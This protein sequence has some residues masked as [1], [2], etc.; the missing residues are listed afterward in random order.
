MADAVFMY[1]VTAGIFAFLV[2]VVF[3]ARGARK[4][5]EPAESTA[6]AHSSEGSEKGGKKIKKFKSDGTPVYE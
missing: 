4:R 2:A 6:E 3:G 1:G 5:H